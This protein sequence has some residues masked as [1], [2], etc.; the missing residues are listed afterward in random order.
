MI[1]I[2]TDT[3]IINQAVETFIMNEEGFRNRVY[4]CLGGV[5][6]I[7]FGTKAKS[8]DEVITEEEGRYRLRKYLNDVTYKKIVKYNIKIT[9]ES[10]LVSIASFD[11]N[12]DKLLKIVNSDNTIDCKKILLYNKVKSIKEDGSIEYKVIDNLD[13]RRHKEYELCIK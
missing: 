5:K 2:A 11:Y 7:G 9:N 6:T 1:S 4:K 13:K 8:D 10:Q 12:T 3:I